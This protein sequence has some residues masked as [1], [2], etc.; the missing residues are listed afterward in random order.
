MRR[1]WDS[2][3]EQASSPV[4]S[5]GVH[6]VIDDGNDDVTHGDDVIVV[7]DYDESTSGRDAPSSDRN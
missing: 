3:E 5:T 2:A 4:N 6:I 1:K 7:E